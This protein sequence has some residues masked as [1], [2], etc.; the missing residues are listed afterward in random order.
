M[1]DGFSELAQVAVDGRGDEVLQGEQAGVA[2]H[3]QVQCLISVVGFD[4]NRNFRF[5]PLRPEA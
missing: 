4:V 1:P 2:V 3:D 5:V